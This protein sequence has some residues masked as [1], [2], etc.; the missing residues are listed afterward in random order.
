MADSRLNAF[1]EW[2]QS[3]LSLPLFDITPLAGD[4]SFR[5]YFR[6][7]TEKNSWIAVDTPIALED[8]RP[9]ITISKLFTTLNVKVPHIFASDIQEGFLLLEDFG[10]KIYLNELQP[11]NA[12][13]LYINTFTPLLQIQSCPVETKNS[14][15]SFNAAFIHKELSFFEEWFLIQHLQ[16]ELSPKVLSSAFD[17]L[18]QSAETQPQVCVHRDYHSRNLMRLD[19]D[20]VGVLDFQD[21]VWGPI[22]YDLVSLLRD[23]YIAW[24]TQQVEKWA[25]IF[26]HQAKERG[27]L[28]SESLEQFIEWFDLMGIQRHLKALFIF[29]RKFHRDGVPHYLNDIPRTFHYIL[30]VSQRYSKLKDFHQALQKCSELIAPFT[31]STI[32]PN[33]LK[34]DAPAQ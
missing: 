28:K 26:Y 18:I 15:P 27:L 23:C 17:Y 1:T 9:F 22:T 14:L 3:Q 11:Q 13:E 20:V 31:P 19:N 10:D 4:A 7:R 21:A 34:N 8:P 2:V 5:R 16:L 12:E 32:L 29:A 30:E 25:C 33:H 6:I 24:P